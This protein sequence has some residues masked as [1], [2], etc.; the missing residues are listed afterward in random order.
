[1]TKTDSSGLSVNTNT[2]IYKYV[3]P[4]C[5]LDYLNLVHWQIHVKRRHRYQHPLNERV[6][7][8]EL[9]RVGA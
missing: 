7:K 8:V 3:C 5:K 6:D 2:T 4:I 9:I 1:M